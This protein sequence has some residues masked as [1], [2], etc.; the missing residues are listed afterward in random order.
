[1][2]SLDRDGDLAGGWVRAC[3]LRLALEMNI[4]S[5]FVN[6]S[7]VQSVRQPVSQPI[8]SSHRN[9]RAITQQVSG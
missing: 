4:A 1:M 2:S 9:H 8:R 3:L 6:E 7:V 5:Q